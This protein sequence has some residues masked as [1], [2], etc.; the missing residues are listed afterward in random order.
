MS[1]IAAVVSPAVRPM[2]T[3]CLHQLIVQHSSRAWQRVTWH[4]DVPNLRCNGKGVCSQ[5]NFRRL[6]LLL[7]LTRRSGSA[8][9]QYR[10]LRFMNFAQRTSSDQASPLRDCRKLPSSFAAAFIIDFL[11]CSHVEAQHASVP[12]NIPLRVQ[13][14]Y[15]RLISAVIDAPRLPWSSAQRRDKKGIDNHKWLLTH[16]HFVPVLDMLRDQLMWQF[17]STISVLLL[18]AVI[19]CLN[20]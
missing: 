15:N 20:I 1:A 2:A 10:V 17:R 19:G 16:F 3:F 12:E 4:Y 18:F 7:L 13:Q 6:L 8:V 11:S 5:P 9:Q 14:P